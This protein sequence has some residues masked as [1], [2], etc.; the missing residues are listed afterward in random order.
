MCGNGRPY[1]VDQRRLLAVD[2]SWRGTQIQG[3]NFSPQLMGTRERDDGTTMTERGGKVSSLT[4][5]PLAAHTP[6]ILEGQGKRKKISWGKKHA[7]APA[8]KYGTKSLR[9]TSASAQDARQFRRTAMAGR[10]EAYER[11]V[12]PFPFWKVSR[13][14]GI[15]YPT[16]HADHFQDV[17]SRRWLAGL[18]AR[19]GR[20][21]KA[22]SRDG[23]VA[24]AGCPCGS[25]DLPNQLWFPLGVRMQGLS[26]GPFAFASPLYCGNLRATSCQP[27][28]LVAA[29]MTGTEKPDA[30]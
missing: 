2:L 9:P 6:I 17:G 25:P 12:A 5:F 14:P 8:Y 18:G 22:R 21:A 19:R 30:A 20:R 26:A 1:G 10:G 28:V 4:E 3:Q 23:R 13:I 29:D 24:R 11:A 27:H 15:P 16:R 7:P